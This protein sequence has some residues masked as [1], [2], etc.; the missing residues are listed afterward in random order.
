MDEKRFRELV[1]DYERW[2]K[3]SYHSKFIGDSLY[4]IIENCYKICSLDTFG[5]KNQTQE[6]IN[7]VQRWGALS[8]ARAFHYGIAIENACKARL[9]YD[10]KINSD[11]NKIT[12]I[13]ND[14]N[15]EE[16]T[17]Q[18]G[19]T[20]P[21]TDPEFLKLLTFQLQSLSKYPIAKTRKKQNEFT[22]RTEGARLIEGELTLSIITQTLKHDILREIYKKYEKI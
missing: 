10:G 21:K 22:G 19:V 17:K 2:I 16:M 9:I 1:L 18:L 5:K 11:G 7:K 8:D 20:S 15:I 13:R 3:A 12:G 4:P 14:H 6:F